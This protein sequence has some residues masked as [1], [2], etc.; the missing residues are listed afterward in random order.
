MSGTKISRRRFLTGAAIAAGAAT[1][2]L[3]GCSDET[4]ELTPVGLPKSWDYEADVV[5]IGYG[6]SGSLAALEAL[7]QG[8][9]VIALE[10]SPYNTGGNLACA[11]GIIHDCPGSDIDEWLKCYIHGTFQ[12]GA[13]E[14]DIRP[15]LQEAID[16]PTWLEEYGLDIEWKEIGG[17]NHTYPSYQME[18]SIA[19]RAGRTGLDLFQAV[20]E[21]NQGLGVD[22]RLG[23]PAKRLIQNAGTKEIVG[24]FADD[25]DGKSLAFKARKGV[26]MACGGYEFNPEMFYN[27]NLPGIDLVGIGTPYNTG[28]GHKMAMAVGAD[29]WHMQEFHSAG[30]NMLKPSLAV[31]CALPVPFTRFPAGWC[32]VDCNGKRFMNESY[33]PAHDSNHKSAW[34][35]STPSAF[36]KEAYLA[37]DPEVTKYTTLTS[38]Y[39]HLPMFAIFDQVMYDAKNPLV[40]VSDE[41]GVM[42]YDSVWAKVVQ[43]VT[44]EPLGG[45]SCKDNEEAIQREWIFK[46]NTIEELA[47]NI[48]GLRPCASEEDAI[49]GIDPVALAATIAT[50]NSYVDAGEDPEFQ[51]TPASMAARIETGPFYAMEV[52]WTLDFTEGGPR[53]NG[54]CQTIDV[55]NE[56]IPRLYSTGEFGSFNSLAYT[57]GGIIQALT[58]G[59][60]AARHAVGLNAWD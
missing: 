49:N 9:S 46:G 52:Q 17:D 3:A 14:K 45:F 38:D 60:I 51:R 19:G 32:Y 7:T 10:K 30:P 56:P 25:A 27:Y 4:K 50:Y 31:K 5:V 48:K 2:G 33:G 42:C 57:F 24:V 15:V 40:V 26:I 55:F 12:T 6:G 44:G 20:D 13:P 18:G 59:R 21:L 8:A 36:S 39:V 23:T 54:N 29:L 58:T 35:Y 22:L 43:P 53:R 16:S 1:V 34:D 28:D 47:A 37:T 11:N 41:T